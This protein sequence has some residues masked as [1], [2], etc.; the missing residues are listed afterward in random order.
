MK[1]RLSILLGLFAFILC[2]S[3]QAFQ[4]EWRYETN[5]SNLPRANV[6]GVASP[7]TPPV[8]VIVSGK[9]VALGEPSRQ[10][11]EYSVQVNVDHYLKGSGPSV[12]T[13]EG[14][15]TDFCVGSRTPVNVDEWWTFSLYLG[16]QSD[17]SD[18]RD[19]PEKLF[20]H[21]FKSYC[22]GDQPQPDNLLNGE[23]VVKLP[24]PLQHDGLLVAP[25]SRVVL[26]AKR[27]LVYAVSL[28]RG[29]K[30][31]G[32]ELPE[33][34]A[35]IRA[36]N[37]TFNLAHDLRIGSIN[38]SGQVTIFYSDSFAS[39]E[40]YATKIGTVKAFGIPMS[41]VAF[42]LVPEFQAS[43]GR[44]AEDVVVRQ[45]RVFKD[46]DISFW[47]TGVPKEI[48]SHVSQTV[49]GIVT[50]PRTYFKFTADGS[51]SISPGYHMMVDGVDISQSS[52]TFWPDG[53]L[54]KFWA[55]QD[56]TIHGRRVKKEEPVC[57]NRDGDV[58]DCE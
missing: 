15:V 30:I 26:N 48:F 10:T 17:V 39:Y 46:Q 35:T 58:V 23:C 22:E 28:S 45:V 41:Q 2:G 19:S 11:G 54:R 3:A 31:D 53:A 52:P 1:I 7:A 55:A 47:P 20:V 42:V 9:V 33:N 21:E 5:I 36:V 6:E 27:E 38:L 37:P 34:T 4:C 14:L 25:Y 16:R 13:I 50:R 18:K 43:G 57:L 40:A 49:H 51:Y 32:I 44:V 56:Q 8:D 24:R 29:S 12:L